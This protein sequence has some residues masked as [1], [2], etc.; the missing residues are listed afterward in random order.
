MTTMTSQAPSPV[1]SVLIYLG[2]ALAAVG[3]CLGA[4]VDPRAICVP[5]PDRRS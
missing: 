3:M 5:R 2:R 1:P 4:P